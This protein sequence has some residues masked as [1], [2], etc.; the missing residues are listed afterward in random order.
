MTKQAK[1][2]PDNRNKGSPD[3]RNADNRDS[4]KASNNEASR[5]QG[6]GGRGR[7]HDDNDDRNSRVTTEPKSGTRASNES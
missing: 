5:S 1:N 2:Q 4:G 6:M 7:S 3:A